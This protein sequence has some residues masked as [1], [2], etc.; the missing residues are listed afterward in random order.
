MST[1]LTAVH[2]CASLRLPVHP[3]PRPLPPPSLTTLQHFGLLKLAINALKHKWI[4]THAACCCNPFPFPFPCCMQEQG[5]MPSPCLPLPH[6][7]PLPPLLGICAAIPFVEAQWGWE[8][9]KSFKIVTSEW[10]RLETN[11]NGTN[12]MEQKAV[13]LELFCMIRKVG[14]GMK[15]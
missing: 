13:S 3:V 9:L 15:H 6:R 8:G 10:K 12:G 14:N 7:T 2:P 1:C 11:G 5:S 4:Y